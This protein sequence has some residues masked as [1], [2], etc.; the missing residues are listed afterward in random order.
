[1]KSAA[2]PDLLHPDASS[3]LAAVGKPPQMTKG[4]IPDLCRAG[5]DAAARYYSHP[6][7]SGCRPLM[8]PGGGVLLAGRRGTQWPVNSKPIGA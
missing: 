4:T 6:P 2:R 1:M 8:A 3:A 7:L 5:P